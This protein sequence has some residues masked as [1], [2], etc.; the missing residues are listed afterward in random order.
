MRTMLRRMLPLVALLLGASLT[1]VP[2]VSAG[3]ATHYRLDCPER[4]N[5]A[6][7]ANSREAF[8]S[9]Y[10]TGHDEPS[11]LFYSDQPGSGNSMRY[12]LTL[13]TDPPHSDTTG[14]FNF[15]LH[16][17]FWFGMAMCDTQSYPEQV[18]SCPPD[19]DSNITSDLAQH[20]G[21]A[22]M[23]MQFYPPGWELWPP[24][25]SCSATQWC[26]ALNIDSLSEDPVNGT[27]LNKVCQSLVGIEYVNFAFITS[28]GV[29]QAPA[30]PVQATATTYT[31]DPSKDLF[32][33][34]GDRITLTM[35]DTS[36]GLFIGVN[37]LTTHQTGS[38]TASSAN[39]FG[40]VRYAPKPS[41]ACDNLPYDFHPMYSTSSPDTRVI[42]AA[43][44]YNI[45]FS[46]EIGH[47]DYCSHVPHDTGKCVGTEGST[48]FGDVVER[49][50]GD[51]Q[52]C[53]K[54]PGVGFVRI[55]GCLGTNAPGFD[56]VPYQNAWPTDTPSSDRPSP[57]LFTSPLTGPGHT[58]NYGS[59]AFEAD[60]PRIEASDLGG[61]CDRTTGD[62]CVKPPPTD[63]GVPAD[64]YPFY[65]AITTTGCQW[66]IG[67]LASNGTTN[68]FGQIDQYG[69]LFLQTYLVFGGGGATTQRYN[70]FQGVMP[71]NPCPA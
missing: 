24:G 19:S 49:R 5:C 31:P 27:T 8:G 52:Y 21:T 3:A 47:F 59:M 28:D 48:N 37:D 20:P 16:P 41:N 12:Q 30:N 40:Q 34:S 22:F 67:D 56:G 6:E 61:S 57:V 1:A 4:A 64:F 25:D 43:H 29:A 2:P 68:D 39:G 23:E 18:G 44:S 26:A 35:H 70:D 32:M 46:D 9:S 58:I 7:V 65:S 53:F 17:A 66:A 11:V 62:G 60:L 10:Y 42:W 50:D 71:T 33:N 51:D 55:A 15:Q 45:A 69:P 38:M 14:S 36:T 54:A 13:P 63:D